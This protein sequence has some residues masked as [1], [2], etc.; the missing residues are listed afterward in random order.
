M[1]VLSSLGLI[2]LISLILYICI[3]SYVN[4]R[5]L[6]GFK[7]PPLAAYSRFWLWK[8]SVSKRVHIAEKEALEK[9]GMRLFSVNIMPAN[10]NMGRLARSHW[11]Q[12]A[13]DG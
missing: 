12:S 11:A 1:A 4:S 5:K 2:L 13:R 8:Q 7:G 9:Y 3:G 6:I 10:A